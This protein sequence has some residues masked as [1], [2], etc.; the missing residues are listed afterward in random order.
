MLED[1]IRLR[2]AINELF[3]IVR[4]NTFML[5]AKKEFNDLL[6]GSDYELKIF[7][8]NIGSEKLS[9]AKEEFENMALK[10]KNSFGNTAISNA[11]SCFKSAL[12][13]EEF[14]LKIGLKRKATVEQKSDIFKAAFD[15][16][17]LKSEKWDCELD[18]YSFF[19]ENVKE[20][21]MPVGNKKKETEEI[22]P[23]CDGIPQRIQKT[24]FFG[25]HS[26]EKD[27]YVW[28]CE[29]GA[30]ALMNEDGNV[31]G[32]LADAILHQKR[33]LVRRAVFELCTMIGLTCFESYRYFSLITDTQIEE[34]SDI[35]YLDLE[36][37]NTALKNFMGIKTTIN[38]GSYPYPKTRDE[39]LMFFLDGG[40][41]SVCNA[42]GFRYGKII[43]PSEVGIDGIKIHTKDG[44][45]SMGF[46]KNLKYEFNNE[47][48]SI[49]HP[50]GKKEKFKMLPEAFR[51]MIMSSEM[52]VNKA[53]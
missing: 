50:S 37:C 34:I 17:L 41:L 30:Y 8:R 27:G 36:Q 38:S 48:M 19:I 45:Q 22:C 5:K 23:Y 18:C 11:Y 12:D 40:R 47:F 49:I 52:N 14:Y 33:N 43:V 26:G 42:Y 15:K 2:K 7:E 3:H 31:I 9:E 39:L 44:I 16:F 1:E 51:S 32:K 53:V 13:N 28:G 46:S 35:E 6:K 29:C 25:P 10:V 20:I 4:M 21:I 24:D